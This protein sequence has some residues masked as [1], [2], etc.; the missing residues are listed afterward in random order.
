[1]RSC[2]KESRII[3]TQRHAFGWRFQ[4]KQ[5]ILNLDNQKKIELFR[6]DDLQ[7]LCVLFLG[8]VELQIFTPEQDPEYGQARYPIVALAPARRANGMRTS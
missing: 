1:M 5:G 2:A 7:G 8:W 3:D 6:D 4:Q